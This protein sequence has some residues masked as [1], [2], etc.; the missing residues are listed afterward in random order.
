LIE[1][2][3]CFFWRG[4]SKL[5]CAHAIFTCH[6]DSGNYGG[7]VTVETLKDFHRRRVQVLAESGA[8]LLAFETIPNKIEA[9]VSSIYIASF[10]CYFF[11][12]L[13]CLITND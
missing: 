9:K 7:G 1:R 8:D 2:N 6:F 3:L 13:V 10:A 12:E 5:I 11:F 4:L